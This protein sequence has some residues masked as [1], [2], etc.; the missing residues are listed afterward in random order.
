MS[1][2][3]SP[4]NSVSQP[5]R[6]PSPWLPFKIAYPAVA[7]ACL[8]QWGGPSRWLRVDFFSGGYFLIQGLRVLR[9]MLNPSRKRRSKEGWR[10]RWGSTAAPGWVSWAL[11]LTMADLAVY[12]DYGHWHLVPNLKRPYLQAFGLLLYLVGVLWMRWTRRY[13]EPAFADNRVQPTLVQSGPFQYIRHPTYAGALMEKIAVALVFA[14]AMGW[15]LVV[16]W[17]LL[18]LR[19]VRLEEVHLHSLFGSEYEAY[20]RETARLVPGI[21]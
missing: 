18:L 10:E 9:S 16:A 6:H 19:Q 1:I 4:G 14:S 3:P 13:L 12:L 7:L 5:R 8:I 15:L 17:S 21:Y 2:I 20:S 11:A